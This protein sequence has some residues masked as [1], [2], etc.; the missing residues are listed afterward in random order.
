MPYGCFLQFYYWFLAHAS[1][2][3]GIRPQALV[4]W[5]GGIFDF[6]GS[7]KHIITLSQESDSFYSSKTTNTCA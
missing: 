7:L 2:V 1:W 5:P 3:G 4:N 6:E